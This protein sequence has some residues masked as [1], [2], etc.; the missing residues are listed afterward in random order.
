MFRIVSLSIVLT[1]IVVLGIT[2][3]KVVAPFLLPLFLAGVVAIL[4][5]PL[6]NYFVKRTNGRVRVAS[7]LATATIVLALLVPISVGTAIASAQLYVFANDVASSASWEDVFGTVRQ[8][9]DSHTDR[10]AEWAANVLNKVRGIEGLEPNPAEVRI[11]TETVEPEESQGTTGTAPTAPETPGE[12]ETPQ[13]IPDDLPPAEPNEFHGG[14]ASIPS[15]AH[16]VEYTTVTLPAQP[17]TPIQVTAAERDAVYDISTALRTGQ[18]VTAGHLK[19]LVKAKVNAFVIDVGDRSLGLFTG[20]LFSVISAVVALFIFTVALYYFF[21]DGTALLAATENLIPVHVEYQREMLQ[22]FARVVRAVVTAT[23]LASVGQAVATTFA[24]GLCGFD[25]LITLF[26]LCFLSSL[27]PMLGTW[28]IWG[29]CVVLLALGGHW[30]SATFLAIYGIAVVGM[31]D[32]VIRTYVLNSDTKLHP[33][34][35]LISVLGGLQVMGLWGVFIGPIVAS[36]LHALV[37]IFNHELTV[38]SKSRFG[39]QAKAAAGALLAPTSAS[40]GEVRVLAAEAG[41]ADGHPPIDAPP[42]GNGGAPANTLPQT[43]GKAGK[44]R[45]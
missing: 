28:L 32:N 29:P 8:G 13:D 18:P 39:D 44:K 1:L 19:S 25:H 40:S 36:C 4:T 41:P 12:G 45:R 24:L 42:S 15:S 6:F 14:T 11:D 31:L 17:D 3:F 34:L 20:V 7:G 35:A 27:I 33:L 21:A 10:L 9:A 26:V 22:Q 30:V 23:F 43:T 37:K 16:D 5:Q 2:F 38:L